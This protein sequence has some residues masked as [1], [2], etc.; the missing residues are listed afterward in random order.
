MPSQHWLAKTLVEQAAN[1]KLC[2]LAVRCA[3]TSDLTRY[4][5]SNFAGALG[6]TVGCP[7]NKQSTRT[8]LLGTFVPAYAF[9]TLVEA[10]K[11]PTLQA[12]G[13]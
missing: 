8:K 11:R 7:P 1:D 3:Q 10:T 6:W 9:Q 4:Q 5:K 13:M 2:R 12:L